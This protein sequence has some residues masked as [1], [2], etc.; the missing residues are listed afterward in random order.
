MEIVIDNYT[1]IIKGQEI[2]KN[3]NCTFSSGKI[4]GLYGKNGSGK[5]MLMRAVAGLIYPTEGAV[6]IDGKIVRKDIDFPESIGVLI[7]NPVFLPYF[8]GYKNLKFLADIKSV[9][10]KDEI[11]KAISDVGLDPEDE[12]K[13]KKYSLGMRQRL[14]IAAAIMEN[15][16]ILLLDEPFNGID[17]DSLDDIRKI[18][19]SFRDKNKIVILACHDIEELEKLT[20]KIFRIKNGR[21]EE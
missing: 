19:L 10:G 7:E 15:P 11:Y 14:G 4:Y 17:E 5:T 6:K 2:L 20:D 12:R 21:L 16:D 3:I 1:K 8:S 9:I 13:V 18:L